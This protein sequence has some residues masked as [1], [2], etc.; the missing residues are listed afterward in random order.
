MST[1][2]AF[3]LYLLIGS[4]LSGCTGQYL[5]IQT[6][7]LGRSYLASY[8]IDTPDPL[9][10]VPLLSQRLFIQWSLP[11]CFLSYEDLHLEI[12]MRFAN[13][14]ELKKEIEIT[15]C[16]GYYLYILSDEDFREKKGIL[17]YKVILLGNQQILEE[18]QHQL[19]AEFL[20]VGEDS[21][22]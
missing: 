18:K 1:L 16:S 10:H 8:A 15:C 20:R 17:T 13:R 11:L 5:S 6:D 3:F 22:Q 21:C 2:K 19:W 12:T 7:Y 4:C 9:L 14:T